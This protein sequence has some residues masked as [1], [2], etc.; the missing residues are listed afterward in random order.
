MADL[1]TPHFARSLRSS[2][3]A[4]PRSRRVSRSFDLELFSCAADLST[5]H[6]LGS[7]DPLHRRLVL[8]AFSPDS[9]LLL[10][11]CSSLH[12]PL[13]LFSRDPADS[14]RPLCSSGRAPPSPDRCRRPPRLAPRSFDPALSSCAP[15]VAI[16]RSP[17]SARS[18]PSALRRLRRLTRSLSCSRRIPSGLLRS[19]VPPR[20]RPMALASPLIRRSPP[21]SPGPYRT[22][23]PAPR[24]AVRRRAAVLASS[25]CPRLRTRAAVRSSR[26]AGPPSSL[27]ARSAVSRRASW[28][29]PVSHAISG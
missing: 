11:H 25:G 15:P 16:L 27:C 13:R 29:C 17:R 28:A 18:C 12:P 10:A 14:P 26:A 23:R 22:P 3:P 8:L 9:A 5:P 4:F 21:A 24:S 7:S 19:S 6:F 1:S 20:L 2:S